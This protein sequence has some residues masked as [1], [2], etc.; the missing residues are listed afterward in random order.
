MTTNATAAFFAANEKRLWWAGFS[1]VDGLEGG[2]RIVLDGSGRVEVLHVHPSHGRG[3]RADAVG[4]SLSAP[5]IEDLAR[6]F[7]AEDFLSLEVS[8]EAPTYRSVV[9]P[10][11]TRERLALG[12]GPAAERQVE[13]WTSQKIPRFKALSGRFGALAERARR[14]NPR[15]SGAYEQGSDLTPP[16]WLSQK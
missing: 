9:I 4:F 1:D 6:A 16:A 5:E 14:M 13:R 12:A 11:G 15:S 7:V 2:I 10:G 8:W 3:S